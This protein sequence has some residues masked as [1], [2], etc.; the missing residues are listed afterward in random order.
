ME[1]DQILR[2]RGSQYGT[3]GEVALVA[4]NIK[5]AMRHSPNWQR[6]PADMREAL[7]M[8]AAKSARILCGDPTH[9]D[10]WRDIEGYAKLISERLVSSHGTSEDV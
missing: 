9:L 4:Q 2:E 7:E 1:V 5:S 8:I 6:L 3:F 10:S